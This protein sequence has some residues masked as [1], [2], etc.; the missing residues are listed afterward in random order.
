MSLRP[1]GSSWGVCSVRP[2]NW[3]LFALQVMISVVWN[4]RGAQCVLSFYKSWLHFNHSLHSTP[5]VLD[6][7]VALVYLHATLALTSFPRAQYTTDL[8]DFHILWCKHLFITLIW[9][10]LVKSDLINVVW[11]NF[12]MV[13]LPFVTAT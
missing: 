5:H 8:P 9:S 3:Y 7:Y 10:R 2:T 13:C 11:L 6:Q 12:A 1:L 4:T